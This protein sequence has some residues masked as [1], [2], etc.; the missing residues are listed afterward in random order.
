MIK[1]ESFLYINKNLINIKKFKGK[2]PDNFYIYGAIKLNINGKNIFT[3]ETI[4]LV[5]MIWSYMINDILEIEEGK[6][7]T[8]SNIPDL[9]LPFTFKIDKDYSIITMSFNG[10]SVSL[11]YKI[12]ISAIS[13]Y[14]KEFFTELFRID[15][16]SK[17]LDEYYLEKIEELEE[18]Y[19]KYIPDE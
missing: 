7:E 4:N 10:N 15:P 18:K 16:S 8:S 3:L 5:D 13:Y 19:G 12:F 17:D 11:E 1:A 6:N 2:L 9:I 14:A